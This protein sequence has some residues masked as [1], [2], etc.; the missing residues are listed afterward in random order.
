VVTGWFW[1][2]AGT[3]IVYGDST[4]DASANISINGAAT[5][6]GI[7]RRDRHRYCSGGMASASIA[8]DA[9]HNNMPPYMYLNF[10]MAVINDPAF[11]P[12]TL[13]PGV[14][15]TMTKKVKAKNCAEVNMVRWLA[16]S[17]RRRTKFTTFALALQNRSI[18]HLIFESHNPAYL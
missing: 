12:L 1:V 2:A 16:N 10:I 17:R 3:G 9:A 8:G 15:A 6:I 4:G 5:N 11:K 7:A 18:H 14:V 13:P